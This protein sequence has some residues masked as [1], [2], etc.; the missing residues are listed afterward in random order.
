MLPQAWH[1][2]LVPS[3]TTCESEVHTQTAKSLFQVIEESLHLHLG[4]AV[5]LGG[6]TPEEYLES[7]HWM[8]VPRK[9]M[10]LGPQ[11]RRLLVEFHM[12][13]LLTQ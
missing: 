12:S 6:A 8:H 10:L 7:S 9:R 4:A 13:S 3:K 11:S 1:V 2:I 5:P